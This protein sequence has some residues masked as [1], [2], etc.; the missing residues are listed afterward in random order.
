[1]GLAKMDDVIG[2]NNDRPARFRLALP[3]FVVAGGRRFWLVVFAV[4]GLALGLMASLL[5]PPDL[6]RWI[7]GVAILPV[8]ATLLAEIFTN[9]RQ[10]SIGLD[11]IA[12]LAM[13][14][15]LTIGETLAGIVVA[16]MYSGGQFLESFAEGRARR[17]MTTLL[18]RVP[19]TA[20]RHV[21]GS[22]QEVRL[23]T[24]VAGDRI[25]VRTGEVVPADGTVIAGA[26]VLDQSALTGESLPVNRQAGDNVLSGS[27]NL[28]ATFDLLVS[29]PPA[30]STYAGI[31][32][33]V[34]AAQQVRA[35]MVRLAD[36]YALWFLA[37]TICL[38]GGAWFVTG[39][40]IRALAVLVVATPCPLILAVPVAII[41][42]VSRIAKRGVLVKGGAALEV[43]A[44]VQVIVI[45]KTGT[46]TEGRA[47][48]LAIDSAN[49]FSPHDVLRL[50][51]TLDLASNHVVAAA[52][53]AA[54]EDRSLALGKPSTVRETAGVGIEGMVENKRVVVGG[55]TFV[56]ERLT[57]AGT[58]Q[59]P[60]PRPDDAFSVTVAVDG[61][62]A[63]HLILA[64]EI[65]ADVPRTLKRFR[66]FGVTRIVLASGDRKDIA[67]AIGSR[68][69]IDE[70]RGDLTPQDKVAIVVR[71]RNR[72]TV[73]MVG[74]G[75]N[76][77]PALAA[78]DVGVALGARG[79]AASSEV[80]DVVLLVDRIDRLA[81]AMEIARRSR[82]IALQSAVIGIGLS[83]IA[84]IVATL[85]YLPPVQG[86][87]LQE[88]IDVGVV[89]NALRA[90]G[91]P[92]SD[93]TQKSRMS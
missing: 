33:L 34:E 64:D 12:A 65:R 60:G 92:R 18:S 47:R 59:R 82:H 83:L 20:L 2:V 43:L 44:R 91:N 93:D 90:L 67:N 52:L 78:A 79:A 85:G 77:A 35:P 13:A 25:L 45:D 63:G 40:P 89:L 70:V 62:V 46:L 24:I 80:A 71:E 48:L 30:E 15:A 68:L 58:V 6:A 28:G 16:L 55:A 10:G 61:V 73:M 14:G 39:D 19:K 51:A 37:I 87:L 74:D 11:L 1:M 72:G 56:R 36:R 49:G 84:M 81:D 5:G 8:L 76:D 41:S 31:V 3:H 27:I 4:G 17:E 21:G 38:T 23:E 53:V 50:A 66:S 22:L 42:G 57:D 26:A 54:A 75:V 29:R 32:R 9:L 88:A 69:D 7:W 86:A